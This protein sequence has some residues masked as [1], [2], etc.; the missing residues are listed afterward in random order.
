MLTMSILSTLTSEAGLAA[1]PASG[2]D[3]MAYKAGP[4]KTPPLHPGPIIKSSLDD[5]GISGRKAAV[6]IGYS[7]NGAAKILRGESPVTPDFA[8]LMGKYLGNGGRIWLDMQ[9]DFDLYASEKKL[10]ARIAKIKT[11]AKE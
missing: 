11:I 3:V 7:V 10:A 8:A 6:D 5:A 4:K 2:A 1:L 9:A